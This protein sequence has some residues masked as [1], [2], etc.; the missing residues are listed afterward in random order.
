[1]NLW[2]ET[3]RALNEHNCSWD[4]VEWVGCY[5]FEIPKE[6]CPKLFD[7]EYDSGYGAPEVAED[8]MIVGKDFYMTRGEY[9]GAEWWEFH[10]MPVRP[11]KVR[12]V[13]GVISTN[14]WNDL[15]SF[16]YKGRGKK[17]EEDK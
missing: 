7:K 5:N 13:R 3:K 14:G 6:D 4:D 9:D 1:M 8:L 16:T 15:E 12:K 11:N 17:K 2:E 10:M